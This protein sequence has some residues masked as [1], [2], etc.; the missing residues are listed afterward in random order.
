MDF[1]N[2]NG[3]VALFHSFKQRNCALHNSAFPIGQI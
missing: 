3:F 2:V 1:S